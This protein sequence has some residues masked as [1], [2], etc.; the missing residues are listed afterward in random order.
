MSS[1]SDKVEIFKA[2]Y[3]AHCMIRF[4]PFVSDIDIALWVE[5]NSHCLNFYK[6]KQP[7][8]QNAKAYA[9]IR[10]H[11]NQA[12]LLCAKVRKRG[13]TNYV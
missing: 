9:L 8:R 1:L 12:D 11:A 7:P 5:E 3:A 6:R 4:D 10:T 13:V 2:K